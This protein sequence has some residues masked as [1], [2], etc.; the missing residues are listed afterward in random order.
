[1]GRP[2]HMSIEKMRNELSN[3]GAYIK[4]TH[5]VFPEGAQ[6]GYAAA[7]MIALE[8]RKQ[9][10][11]LDSSWMFNNPEESSNYDPIFKSSTEDV[12]KA[13]KEAL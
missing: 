7:I 4:P 2:T 6:C 9:V 10:T 3:I 13:Q 8:Y 11:Q 12:T 5:T 1:M